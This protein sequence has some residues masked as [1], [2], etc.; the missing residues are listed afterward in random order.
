MTS[1]GQTNKFDNVVNAL[2]F[3]VFTDSPDSCVLPFLK[4]CAPVLASKPKSLGGW[5]MYP[6]GPAPIPQQGLL[7]IKVAQHPALHCGH[8][9]ARF[10]I[11]TQEWQDGTPGISALRVWFYFN[12][13]ADADKAFKTLVEMFKAANTRTNIL[14][15]ADSQEAMLY[16][17]EKNWISA[18]LLSQK[19]KEKDFKYNILFTYGSDNGEPW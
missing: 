5:T 9:G 14:R 16:E 6:P 11:L 15:H 19:G 13:K 12:R 3:H 7:S 18:K 4:R 8:S 1:Q 10:D 2:Q 17:D